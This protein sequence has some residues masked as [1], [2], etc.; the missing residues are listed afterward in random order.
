ML[1]AVLCLAGLTPLR[2]QDKKSGKASVIEVKSRIVN[3]DGKPVS[4]A[5]VIAGEGSIYTY[6]DDNGR[7]SVFAKANSTVLVEALGYKTAVINLSA[8]VPEVIKLVSET[9]LKGENDVIDRVDGS[10]TYQHDLTAAIGRINVGDMAK[11]PDLTLTNALQG[12]AAGLIAISNGGGLGNNGSTLYVRGQHAGGTAAIVV[13]DGIERSIDDIAVEEIGSIEVLKDAPAKI[14]YGPRATNGVILVTTKRGEA[15]KRIINANLEYGVTPVTRTPSYLNAYDYANLFNEARNND[16]LADYYLPYQLEGYKNSAGENDMLYPNIDWYDRFTRN[17]GTFRKASLEF[18]GGNNSVRYALVTS[19][20][21]GSGYEKVADPTQLHR[22]N[23]RGNLD[24]KIN[25]FLTAIADVAA[26]L[27]TK[28]WYG[29]ASSDLYGKLSTYRPNEYPFMMSAEECGL[30]PNEDGSPYYGASLLH[31]DNVYVDMTYGGDKDE[32]Y[33]NSQTD[34]GLNFDFDKYVKGLF[35]DA[36]I[37]FDNYSYQH[38]AMTRTY[39]TYAVDG[40]LDENGQQ[41][42]RVTQVKKVNQSDDI[43]VSSHVT[44]RTMGFR[45]DGGYKGNTGKHEYSA[46][47]AFRYYKDEVP[48]ANQNCVTSN[49]TLRLNYGWNSKF[50]AEAVVG[51]TGS[52]QFSKNRFEPVVSGSLGYVISER[53]YLKVKV[54]G[55]HLGYNPN[56]NYLLYKTAWADAGNYSLGN[57]NNTSVHITQI[58]RIGNEYIDWVT[59]NEGN[60]GFEGS[61]LDNRLA[62]EVNAFVER[63]DNIITGLNSKFSDLIGQYS[64]SFN[65]G[66]VRNAGAE[67]DINWSDKAA[68]G[69]FRYTI[70]AN[71]TFTRNCVVKTDE[72][73]NIESYRSLVGHPT[74]G[75]FALQNEG[76]FGKDVAIEGHAKQLYG[77]YTDGDIAYKDLNGDGLVDDKDQTYIGQTFPLAAIGVNIDLKYKG[78]GLYIQ[79]TS[80]LGQSVM[81]NNSY[82]RNTGSDSYSTYA[83]DRY[84]P[85]NNPEGTLPRLTTTNGSNSYM[86]SDFWFKKANWFRL[87]DVELSYTHENRKGHGFCKTSKFFVRGT[88][89]FVLSGIKDLDPERL[90]AGVT[91]YPVYRTVTCGVTVGF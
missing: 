88:N 44:T 37:T 46:I 31:T 54:S 14:L 55:G 63:R 2:G 26:R 22:F 33:V 49:A 80:N 18:R 5:S 74:S 87:K 32:R 3:E 68:G 64:P 24:I 77:F 7:F 53:P 40:Y 12:R 42:M 66:S 61:V 73:E 85:V 57:N 89:L 79:G 6:S 45:F 58:K 76:L 71:V 23:I 56:G 16:G 91:N 83:L 38:T 81:L 15:N 11:Y 43:K 4:D 48:G 70:G 27:E 47:A 86:D 82:Y 67:L 25:D 21:G 60:I 8:G 29:M 59:Q 1:L 75:V 13:V 65:Y 20:T 30:E 84:H 10:Y 78:F 72:L 34:F 39:A 90:D 28:T 36:F 50:L 69:K 51:V 17:L 19:Y 62:F 41:Q 35:A 9:F 52:N